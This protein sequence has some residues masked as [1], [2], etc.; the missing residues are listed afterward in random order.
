MF[1]ATQFG[2]R[3]ACVHTAHLEDHVLEHGVTFHATVYLQCRH[4]DTTSAV[5]RR[6][7]CVKEV[8]R[9]MSVN[10]LKLTQHQTELLFARVT[11]PSGQ[12]SSTVSAA[13]SSMQY[14]MKCCIPISDIA[15]R[16]HLRF[17]S[18]HQ[19]FVPGHR[20]SMFGGQDLSVA[21][22]RRSAARY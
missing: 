20:C 8:S 15:H 11:S 18:C 22:P 12:N 7:N 1:R 4:D 14:M 13:Q 10:R 2:G 16:Q 21:D 6:E 3:S 19:V 9:W 5:L 17:A